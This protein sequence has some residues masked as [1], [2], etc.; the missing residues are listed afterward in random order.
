MTLPH[1]RQWPAGGHSGGDGTAPRP[2]AGQSS[3]IGLHPD[4]PA[5]DRGNVGHTLSRNPFAAENPLIVQ[6]ARRFV[7]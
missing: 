2:M 5:G 6:R 4:A 7:R 3:A 1:R